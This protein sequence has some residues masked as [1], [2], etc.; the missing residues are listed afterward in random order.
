[1]NLLQDVAAIPEINKIKEQA[2][3]NNKY[4]PFIFVI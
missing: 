3:K 1:M 2:A 4:T